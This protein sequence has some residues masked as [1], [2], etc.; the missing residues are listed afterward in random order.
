MSDQRKSLNESY[1]PRSTEKSY[2][3]T[4]KPKPETSYVP[5]TDNGNNPANRPTPPG[6]K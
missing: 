2:Q 4:T 5:I 3:P 6:D 1:I